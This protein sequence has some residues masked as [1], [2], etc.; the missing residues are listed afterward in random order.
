MIEKLTQ[1]ASTDGSD[2]AV[3]PVIGV[4]LMVAI[5]VILAA[6]IGSFVL[7]LGDQLNSQGPQVSLSVTAENQTSLKN[8]VLFRVTHNGGPS[9]NLAETEIIVRK[10]SDNSLIGKY[11]ADNSGTEAPANTQVLL[12]GS[13][14]PN[15]ATAFSQGDQ[16]QIKENGADS[17]AFSAGTQY[18]IIIRDSSTD[19]TLTTTTITLESS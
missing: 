10:A 19:S 9:L 7:G 18:E 6:V 13:V 3:S 2:R 17:S 11:T 16:L 14:S 12:N 5:T 8:D 1:L 4:I 15:G